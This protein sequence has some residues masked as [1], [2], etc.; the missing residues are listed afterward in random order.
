MIILEENVPGSC[1]VFLSVSKEYFDAH[2]NM[3]AVLIH[4]QVPLHICIKFVVQ[5]TPISNHSLQGRHVGPSIT[6]FIYMFILTCREE[7][8]L[9]FW[10]YQDKGQDCFSSMKHHHALGF[11]LACVYF[12]FNGVFKKICS[13]NEIWLWFDKKKVFHYILFINH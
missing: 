12:V 5:C 13:A 2:A 1:L 9:L 10:N 4:A 8:K 6:R 11:I 7:G 3:Y